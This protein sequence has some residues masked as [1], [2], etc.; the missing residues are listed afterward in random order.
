M[1]QLPQRLKARRQIERRE[2]TPEG[3][4]HQSE[5]REWSEGVLHPKCGL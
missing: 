2:C 1:P 4:L 3:V 5:R